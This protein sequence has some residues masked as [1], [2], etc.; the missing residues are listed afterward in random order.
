MGYV[1]KLNLL[2]IF[3]EVVPLLS[4]LG[5]C[6]PVGATPELILMIGWIL[7]LKR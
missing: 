3:F 2:T 5:D 7:M 4:I 6:L 1:A